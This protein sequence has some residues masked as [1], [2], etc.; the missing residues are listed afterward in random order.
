MAGTITVESEPGAGSLFRVVL[1]FKV[2]S[3]KSSP[4]I[5]KKPLLRHSLSLL[6][7]E[8]DE[9]NSKV[10]SELLEKEGYRVTTASGGQE[11]INTIEKTCFDLVLMDL[12]MPGMD[13]L[14]ATKQ[15]RNLQNGHTEGIK[16]IA[17]TGDIINTVED[18]C[19]KAGMDGIISKPIQLEI[20]NSTIASIIL[21]SAV[22]SRHTQPI[23]S[24][25]LSGE[26]L[27]TNKVT[28][29]SP[30]T[31]DKPV[32][33]AVHALPTAESRV[34]D[35][36]DKKRPF[37]DKSDAYRPENEK[38]S[39][40]N[41]DYLEK[42]EKGLGWEKLLMV[43]EAFYQSGEHI[44]KELEYLTLLNDREGLRETSH[45]LKGMA[46][47]LGLDTLGGV[48]GEIQQQSQSGS[49]E[50]VNLLVKKI[51]PIYNHSAHSLQQ[52]ISRIKPQE[53]G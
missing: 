25:G 20:L 12:H 15:I 50:D 32:N 8:D 1:T 37:Y 43:S 35:S 45:R 27:I 52:F 18:E 42:L 23:D 38:N 26:T 46:K 31:P 17:F 4:S 6:L 47:H 3:E 33:H 14:Q 9:I 51:V 36:Q 19:L 7:V 29:I 24:P 41:W 13:G 40:L 30:D 5:K 34:M 28:A 10:V 44:L 49:Q 22:G 53:S 2:H 39:L 11:A 21:D 16:I 48:A